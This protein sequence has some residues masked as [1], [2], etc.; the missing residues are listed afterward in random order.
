MVSSELRI[1]ALT[2]DKILE[3]QAFLFQIIDELHSDNPWA[4]E[5]VKKAYSAGRLRDILR[6]QQ[7]HCPL[8]LDESGKCVGLGL[9]QYEGGLGKIEWVCVEQC[10]RGHSNG[11]RLLNAMCTFLYLRGCHRVELT[12]YLGQEPLRRFYERHGFAVAAT[13]PN[14]RYGIDIWYMIRD[15]NSGSNAL[16]LERG[17]EGA[18]G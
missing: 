15:L 2:E 12:T 16:T 11:S 17:M 1:T 13:L 10:F 4:L 8:I 18:G 3:Y 9:C 5:A 7:A 6:N 14:H